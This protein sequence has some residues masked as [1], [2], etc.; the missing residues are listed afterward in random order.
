MKGK[1]PDFPLHSVS[2]INKRT[3]QIATVAIILGFFM[4]VIYFSLGLYNIALMVACFCF[5]IG[6]LM[7][8]NHKNIIKNTK[9]PLV[10]FVSISLIAFAANEGYGTGQYLYYFPSIISIPIIVDNQK[11]YFNKV[12]F[13]F[14]ISGTCFI[15]CVLVGILHHPW[16][17]V[18][19][20]NRARIFLINAVSSLSATIGFAYINVSLER[21]YLKFLIDQKNN[22]INSRTQFLSTMGHELRTPLNGIIG[23]I[24]LLKKTESLPEQQEYFNILKYCSDQMLYQVND[25]L[26]FNKIEAGKLEIHAVDVNLNQL[27]VNSV[28]PFINL[29]EAKKLKLL[30]D[31]DPDLNRILLVDDVRIIQILN[32]LLSNAGKFTNAGFVKLSASVISRDTA[33]IRVKFTVEDTGN[34]IAKED[35]ERVFDSF[36]QVFDVNTRKITGSGLGLTICNQILELMDSKMELQSEKGVGSTFSFTVDFAIPTANYTIETAPAIKADSLRGMNILVVEDNQI[37]MIIAQKMLDGLEAKS[38][39][40]YNGE[41]AIAALS[42]EHAPFNIILMD[43]EMPVMDGYTAIKI[44]KN[45]WAHIP[46]LAFTA[47]MMDNETLQELRNIGFK[48]YVSKPFQNQILFSQIEKYALAPDFM[49][50]Q[51]V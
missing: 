19:E 10:V 46:V 22:T 11:T 15:A 31:V 12:I 38:V 50:Q 25:I 3:G 4:S 5:G 7:F 32:N 51:P 29:F 37:N 16:E 2:E 44:I 23:V 33:T 28:M 27:L 26:D 47:T 49:L 36:D 13:Y 24:D 8:L 45:R 14:I 21:K 39:K 1:N 48:D 42:A 35:Q 41:E 43:L 40:A 34:G 6:L 30:L 20:T 17:T 9:L 18:S